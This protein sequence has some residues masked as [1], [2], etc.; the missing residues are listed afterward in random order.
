MADEPVSRIAWKDLLLPQVA[1]NQ[2]G[3]FVNHVNSVSFLPD[4]GTIW[5]RFPERSFL[6]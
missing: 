2:A 3:F 1:K 6:Q 5:A 4:V